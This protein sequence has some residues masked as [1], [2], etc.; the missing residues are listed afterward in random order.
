MAREYAARASKTTAAHRGERPSHPG[1]LRA[2]QS[3]IRVALDD[4][5]AGDIRV[6]SM[7]AGQGQDLLGVLQHHVRRH[8]VWARLVELDEQNVAIAR[9]T[10]QAMA[11]PRV[12]IVAGDAAQLDLY[13]AMVPADLVLVCGVFGN[14]PDADIARTIAYLPQVCGPGAM[15]SGPGI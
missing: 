8:D 5:P 15:W 1:Q 7:C 6:V 13:M 14:I 2:V 11:L 10:A 12:E 4:C 9:M 3:R